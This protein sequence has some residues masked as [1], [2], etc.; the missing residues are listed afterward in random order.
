MCSPTE[1]MCDQSAMLS[2]AD[3]APYLGALLALV[4]VLSVV[5]FRRRDVP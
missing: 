3:A 2:L 5:L 1:E 4:M